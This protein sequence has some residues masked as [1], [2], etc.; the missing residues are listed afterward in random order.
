MKTRFHYF[1]I[2]LVVL[3]ITN[4]ANAA[5][6]DWNNATNWSPNPAYKAP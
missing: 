5:G 6:G 2:A 3:A 4:A 1:F